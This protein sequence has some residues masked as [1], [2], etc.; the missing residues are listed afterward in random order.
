MALYKES[1][2]LRWAKTLFFLLNMLA[3][4]LLVCAPPLL[5]VILD[6]LLPSA[7]LSAASNPAFSAVGVLSQLKSYRFQSSLVDVPLVSVARSLLILCVYLVC[8]G[9]GPYLG[10][11]TVCSIGSIGFVSLKATTMFGTEMVQGRR[12][13]AI[14]NKDGAAVD[15]LFLSSMA[16]AMAH[17][18]VGYRTSC[19]ERKKLLV[20]RIDIEAVKLK[21]IKV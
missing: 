16:L 12:L 10:I 6:L 9:R 4:L 13:L 17:I 19:R 20:Y 14:G 3:S 18:L 2:I 8:E 15:A 11:T 21:D 5:V 7:L 1:R